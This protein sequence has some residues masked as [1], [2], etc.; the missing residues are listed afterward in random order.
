MGGACSQGGQPFAGRALMRS[1]EVVGLQ[2]HGVE[3]FG[4]VV[5]GYGEI[6]EDR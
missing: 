5:D 2:A 3:A 6:G 1:L 4:R